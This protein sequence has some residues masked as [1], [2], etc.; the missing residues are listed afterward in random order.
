MLKLAP[1]FHIK[2]KKKLPQDYFC[3][4]TFVYMRK[5]REKEEKI[6]GGGR[7]EN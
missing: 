3:I 6:E 4:H 2:K 1:I 5:R 7:E